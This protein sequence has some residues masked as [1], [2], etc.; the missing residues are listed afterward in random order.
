MMPEVLKREME[1]LHH[2]AEIAR[3]NLEI[4]YLLDGDFNDE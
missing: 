3:L 4:A 1:I 2:E